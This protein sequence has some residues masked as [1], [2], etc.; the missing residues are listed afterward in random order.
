MSF[1][2]ALAWEENTIIYISQ[3]IA[4]YACWE[5]LSDCWICQQKPWSAY[6]VKDPLAVPITNV[7]YDWF[8]RT[9]R[10]YERINFSSQGFSERPL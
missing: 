6:A 9:H 5:K 10:E 2:L 3:A 4:K 8:P 7:S 1:T